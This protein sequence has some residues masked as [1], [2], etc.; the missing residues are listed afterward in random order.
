QL[1]SKKPREL[2]SF[3]K[4]P[5]GWWRDT[6]QRL[7]VERQSNGIS[8]Q[9]RELV[10]NSDTDYVHLHALWTLNGLDKAGHSIIESALSDPSPH[11]RAAAIRMAEPLLAESDSRIR[12]EV[13]KLITD[14]SSIVQRQLAASVGE[15]PLESRIP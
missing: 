13:M 9:L 7:L 4:H 5:N 15:F 2:V 3:L 14:S 8:P 11:I 1:S 12:N 6:A 10:T